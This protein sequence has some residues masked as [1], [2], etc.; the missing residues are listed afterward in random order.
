MKK[1]LSTNLATLISLTVVFYT[2]YYLLVQDNFL[3]TSISSII[4]RAHHLEIKSHLIVLGLLPIYIAM[5][6]FG[7]AMLGMYIGSAVQNILSRNIK[8]P[9]IAQ[10]KAY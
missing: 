1:I 8:R 5:V 9:Y 10:K 2:S 3:H 4:H 7:S 6:I